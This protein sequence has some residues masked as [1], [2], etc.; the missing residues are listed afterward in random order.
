MT[1]GKIGARDMMYRWRNP[2]VT[3]G[4][5]AMWDGEWNAGGGVHDPNAT[6][7][8]DL[9]GNNDLTIVS[10]EQTITK[11]SIVFNDTNLGGK[12]TNEITSIVSCE[13]CGMVTR[14][15]ENAIFLPNL[16]TS[17]TRRAFPLWFYKNSFGVGNNKRGF[18]VGT[19]L[20]FTVY[21]DFTTNSSDFSAKALNG[22][23]SS[24]TGSADIFSSSSQSIGFGF[25]S[26]YPFGG[27]V[28]NLRIYSRTLTPDEIA[29]NYAIDKRRFNLP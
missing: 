8:K 19:N 23:L 18:S 4:L 6:L 22:V 10:G 29:A 25:R 16:E 24:A 14:N 15:A 13:F 9:V 7:W 20:A 5:V 1:L 11:N 26:Q 27:V 2:Y 17:N 21:S 3:D 28:Y 12:L